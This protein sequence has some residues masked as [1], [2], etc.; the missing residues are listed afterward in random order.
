ML[1]RAHP[2]QGLVEGL[3]EPIAGRSHQLRVEGA[4]SLQHLGLQSPCLFRSI[5]QSKDSLFIACARET[6]G[7]EFIGNLADARLLLR[8]LL[9]QL[10]Q[11]RL[12]NAGDREHQLLPHVGRVLHSLASEF[13]QLQAILKCE[14]SGRTQCGVLTKGQPSASLETCY[15]FLPVRPQLLDAREPSNEHCRL[16]IPRLLELLLRSRDAEL[17]Q[18]IAKNILGFCA[19]VL[20]GRDVLDR[21]HH[22]H[23]LRALARKQQTKREGRR[24]CRDRSN[25]L[26]P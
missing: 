16:A 8:S 15:R 7:K 11:L 12:L 14:D 5:L 13:H 3:A 23:V 20:H 26:R 9:A 22:L 19:H 2:W 4:R 24:A 17:Q 18:V 6:F 1:W 10:L 21:G 25:W